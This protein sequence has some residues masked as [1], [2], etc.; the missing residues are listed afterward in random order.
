MGIKA[1]L[2]GADDGNVLVVFADGDATAAKDAL[3]VVAHKVRRAA[4]ILG[5]EV[6]AAHVFVLID[7]IF[8]RERLQFAIQVAIAA[9]AVHAVVAQNELQ[10]GLS[11]RAQFRRVGLNLH[12]IGNLLHARRRVAAYA[13]RLNEADA[14]GRDGVD[15]AKIAQCRDTNARCMRRF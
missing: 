8:A 1:A 14:A 9:Q 2:V 6:L 11:C 13:G 15:F 4:L 7:A 12:A 10:R 5:L 3:A